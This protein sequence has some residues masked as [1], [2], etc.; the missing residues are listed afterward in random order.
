M[1]LSW[2]T[3]VVCQPGPPVKGGR[4]L[5]KLW[6][7]HRALWEDGKNTTGTDVRAQKG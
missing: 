4:L 2:L 7:P 3:H 6:R 5:L 1:R